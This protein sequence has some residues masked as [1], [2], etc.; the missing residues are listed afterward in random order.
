MLLAFSFLL[1]FVPA[2]TDVVV[3]RRIDVSA[4]RAELLARD[5]ARALNGAKVEEVRAPEQTLALLKKRGAVDPSTCGARRACVAGLGTTLEAAVVVSIDLGKVGNQLGVIL[6]AIKPSDG[7]VLVT[8]AFT[9]PLNNGEVE[10]ARALDDFALKLTSRVEKKPIPPDAPVV[11][12]PPRLPV[13]H[14]EKARATALGAK[15]VTGAAIVAGA[16]S[17]TFGVLGVSAASS[18]SS[19]QYVST[20]GPASRLTRAEADALAGMANTRYAL[21]GGCI[22]ASAVL[23]GVALY[24][25]N[26]AY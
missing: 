17:L 7:S 21:A 4:D 1:M 19:A 8:A 23:T 2:Q 11:A 24:W 10:L 20:S 12:R 26:K 22:A 13:L 5:L 6:I 16:T 9:V 25:W 3:S 18:L 14:E 15:L